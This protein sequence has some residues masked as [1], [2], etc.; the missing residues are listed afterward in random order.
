MSKAAVEQNIETTEAKATDKVNEAADKTNQAVDKA[1]QK[2]NKAVRKVADSAEEG[3]DKA[4][5]VLSDV[6]VYARKIWL[7]GLGAYTKAGQEGA[8]YF[9]EL[10]KTG[11]NVEQQGKK[12]INEQ[13]EAA[14]SQIDNVKSNVSSVKGKVEGRLDKIEK[15][16]DTRVASALN[17][18]GIPS[19]QDIEVLSA[20]LDELSALLEQVAQN[21]K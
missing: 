15:A 18:I 11:E 4:G 2:T 10:V 14:N 9:K 12:L 5:T 19:K 20:K 7:A 1:A 21:K 13:V 8:E 6:K 3:A 16:F 17:R